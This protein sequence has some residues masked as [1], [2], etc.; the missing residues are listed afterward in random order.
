MGKERRTRKGNW[1][2]EE[3]SREGKKPKRGTR[4]E[5]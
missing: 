2:R 3:K 4:E 1:T 5:G